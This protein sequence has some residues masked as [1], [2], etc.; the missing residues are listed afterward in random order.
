MAVDTKVIRLLD[1][2]DPQ[3]RRKAIITLADSRDLT[4]LAPLENVARKDPDPKLRDLAGRAAAHLKNQAEKAAALAAQKEEAAAPV[5]QVSEKQMARGRSFVDE[6]MS[7]VINKDLGKASKSLAKALQIDPSL[8]NDQYFLSLVGQVFDTT[9]EEGLQRLRDGATRGEFIKDQKNQKIKTRKDN[10][11]AQTVD[12]GWTSTIFDLAVYAVVIG[13][14]TFLSPLVMT[15]IIAQT[16]TYQESLEREKLEQEV[17][18]VSDEMTDMVASVDSA[19]MSSF[20]VVGLIVGV[21]SAISMLILG[22]ITHMIATKLFGGV[23]TMHFMMSQLVPFYSMTMPIFF[24][25]FIIVMLMVSVGAG[26]FGMLCMPIMGLANMVVFFKA[27][28]RVG[29]AYDFGSLKGCLSMT[30]ASTLLYAVGTLITYLFFNAAL[31][32][33][34]NSMGMV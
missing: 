12:Y 31:S 27:T 28:D 2:K 4:A 22:F 11:R 30:L 32:S 19:G 25:W 3:Q 1:H 5:V 20:L 26:M 18:V 6:A 29:K 16:V 13:I 24:I 8:K 14:I 17:I 9:P 34:L 33:A 10:H 15:R 21:G 23:G 7:L